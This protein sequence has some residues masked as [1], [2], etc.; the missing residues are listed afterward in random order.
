MEIKKTNPHKK[1]QNKQKKNSFN[2]RVI[3]IIEHIVNYCTNQNQKQ[4]NINEI[5]C[6]LH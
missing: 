4:K 6:F 5:K 1:K 2:L 3:S